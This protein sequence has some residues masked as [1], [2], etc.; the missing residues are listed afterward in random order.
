M[1]ANK[2]VSTLVCGTQ[3]GTPSPGLFPWE[4]EFNQGTYALKVQFPNQEL[5][6]PMAQDSSLW[7]LGLL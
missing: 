7:P 6:F 1:E 3:T 2:L 5:D 4:G